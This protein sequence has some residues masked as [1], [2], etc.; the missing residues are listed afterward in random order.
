[1]RLRQFGRQWRVLDFPSELLHRSQTKPGKKPGTLAMARP[2]A[3]VQIHA[4]AG[5]TNPRAVAGQPRA[6]DCFLFELRLSSHRRVASKLFDAMCS[7]DPW[8]AKQDER[9]HDGTGYAS[10]L[11]KCPHPKLTGKDLKLEVIADITHRS[12]C[13]QILPCD[14]NTV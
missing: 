8:H 2:E 14:A 7:L 1:M 10:P 5:S 4:T 3:S 12:A 13:T 6:S 11:T 9:E